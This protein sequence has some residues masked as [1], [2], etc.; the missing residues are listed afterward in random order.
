MTT[1]L[2]E[3]L[4][5]RAGEAGLNLRPAKAGAHPADIDEMVATIDAD[6]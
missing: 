5:G 3:D 2:P 4:G 6:Q 1:G